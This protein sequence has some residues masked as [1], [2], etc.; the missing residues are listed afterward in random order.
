MQTAVFWT[1]DGT[2][3]GGGRIHEAEA[4][5]ASLVRAGFADLVA[6]EDSDVLLYD[7][8]LLRGLM[9]G[10]RSPACSASKQGKA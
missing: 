1:G 5:A 4:Y 3:T 8:P 2:R 9:G 6:S 7:A 10:V